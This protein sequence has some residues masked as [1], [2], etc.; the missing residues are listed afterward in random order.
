MILLLDLDPEKP[1]ITY[2]AAVALWMVIWW[3]TEAVPLA[4]TALLPVVVFPILKIMPGREVAGLYFN[5]VIFL[6]LGGFIVALAMERWQLHR[7]LALTI[8]AG[9]GSSPR[10]LILSGVLIP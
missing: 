3:L 1:A 10:R 7:R 8:I 4:A 9:L 2:T 5:N 6:F